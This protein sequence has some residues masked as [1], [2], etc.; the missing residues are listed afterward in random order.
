MEY[1]IREVEYND[2]DKGHLNLLSQLSPLDNIYPSKEEYIKQLDK[3]KINSKC[4]VIEHNNNIIASGT[5][6]IEFKLI[7]GLS[8]IGHIEDVVID[9]QFRGYGL[10]KMIMNKLIQYA[11]D[12]RCYK[13]ILSCSKANEGFYNTFGF[14]KNE[15]SKANYF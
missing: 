8:C 6:L 10:G 4:Y 9:K 12:V 13:V 3:L 2:Y 1:I 5:I 7:R 15:L 11:K 14:N